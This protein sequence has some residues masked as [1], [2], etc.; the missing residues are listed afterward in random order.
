MKQIITERVSISMLDYKLY[1]TNA[2]NAPYQLEIYHTKEQP[3]KNI[4]VLNKNTQKFSCKIGDLVDVRPKV[5][6]SQ[7]LL[8]QNIVMNEFLKN[9]AHFER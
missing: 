9:Y 3:N 6:V 1:S 5:L 8:L 7:Y 2:K 4:G